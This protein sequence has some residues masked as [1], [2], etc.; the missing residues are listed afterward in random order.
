M[1]RAQESARMRKILDGIWRKGDRDECSVK[2]IGHGLAAIVTGGTWENCVDYKRPWD[3]GD[4]DDMPR[5]KSVETDLAGRWAKVQ[6]TYERL[7]PDEFMEVVNSGPYGEYV[8]HYVDMWYG[9]V[10]AA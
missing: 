4:A 10:I 3:Y 1:A 2:H 5:S 8:M 7:G 6:A 9:G